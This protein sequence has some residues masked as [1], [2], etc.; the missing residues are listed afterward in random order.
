LDAC[1]VLIL[2]MM[3]NNASMMYILEVDMFNLN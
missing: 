3:T 2:L 1:C